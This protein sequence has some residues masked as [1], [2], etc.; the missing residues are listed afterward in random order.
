MSDTETTGGEREIYVVR[1]DDQYRWTGDFDAALELATG[2][3]HRD[4]HGDEDHADDI[5]IMWSP[6]ADHFAWIADDPG[7]IYGRECPECGVEIDAGSLRWNGFA[8]E[9]KNPNV[10]PQA[11]HHAILRRSLRTE[12]A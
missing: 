3:N 12:D 7:D 6:E 4:V 8:W 10:H 2:E 11:G 5:T 1:N 9:H